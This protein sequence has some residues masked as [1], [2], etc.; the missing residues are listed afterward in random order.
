MKNYHVDIFTK[1]EFFKGA[2]K[3]VNQTYK[4]SH[5]MKDR[6][7]K[8]QDK[9]HRITLSGLNRAVFAVRCNKT[10]PFEFQVD[11][12][13]NVVKCVI[14]TKYNETEDISIVFLDLGDHTLIKTAYLNA[15][16]DNHITLDESKYSKE[17]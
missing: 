11:E 16:T 17:D 12:N 9:S 7:D 8:P 2:N 13:D 14:R 15:S 4:L 3:I 10:K 5:H 1:E 6:I